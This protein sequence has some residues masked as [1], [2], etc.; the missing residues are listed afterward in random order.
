M[1]APG[2]KPGASVDHVLKRG[3]VTGF[4]QVSVPWQDGEHDRVAAT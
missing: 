1:E 2:K 4:Y 3:A